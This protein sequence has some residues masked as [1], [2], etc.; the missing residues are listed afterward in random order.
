MTLA[1]RSAA[2][3]GSMLV[4][5]LF[6][7][8][9]P[10][11]DVAATVDGS[12]V[13]VLNVS[14][15]YDVQLKSVKV[16]ANNAAELVV[17]IEASIL[18]VYPVHQGDGATV[19][20]GAG[21]VRVTWTESGV[22]QSIDSPEILASA[23]DT[24]SADPAPYLPIAERIVRYIVARVDAMVSV[25]HVE[26]FDARG[27]QRLPESA[28]AYAMIFT[29]PAEPTSEQLQVGDI[30]DVTL[31]V[32]VTVGYLQLADDPKSSDERGLALRAELHQ[33]LLSN[34][35]YI[36]PDTGEALAYD[37]VEVDQSHGLDDA[38]SNQNVILA[39]VEVD[40]MFRHFIGVPHDG[41]DVS[42][43]RS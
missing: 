40:V 21:A 12:G 30:A 25:D 35:D 29:G 27:L 14:R 17:R 19:S 32:A 38:D 13:S 43:K 3:V 4:V 33:A 18:H 24:S 2:V 5:E 1:L 39:S 16:T 15:D 9:G 11:I 41:P 42:P 10:T 37:V 7:S 8:T 26:R 6:A 20:L 31:T 28:R 36:E 34:R 23:I 22:E